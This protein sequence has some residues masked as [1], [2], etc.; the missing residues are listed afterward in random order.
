VL[1]YARWT[2]SYA[3]LLNPQVYHVS[4]APGSYHTSV[5]LRW[6]RQRRHHGFRILEEQQ[7]FGRGEGLSADSS[8]SVVAS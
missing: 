5:A 6:C 2:L 8:L 1:I 3:Q 7:V 4:I